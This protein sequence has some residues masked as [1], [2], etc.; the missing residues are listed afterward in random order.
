MAVCYI[1]RSDTDRYGKLLE[2]LKSSANRGRDEY[3]V[4][5]TDAFDL[6]V[7]ESGEFDTKSYRRFNGRGDRGSRGRNYMLA[8]R[9]GRGSGGRGSDN[10]YTFSRMNE[11][12]SSEIVPGSDDLTHQGISC[13]GCSFLGHYRNQC[14]YSS[15]TGSVSMHLGIMCAQGKVFDIPSSWIL[16]DTCSTCDVA[17]NPA[18]VNDIRTCE[19]NDRLTAYTNGGEQVYNLVAN[20][21]ILPIKVHLKKSSMATI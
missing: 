2:D 13:Y 5:L 12:S 7:R 17:N 4:T 21:N 20:L 19:P 11:N 8:Q 14:P 18:L 15:R 3:P 16:L 1:L 10:D 6:L 9:G